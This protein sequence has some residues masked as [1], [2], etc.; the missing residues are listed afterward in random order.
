MGILRR[1][2]F[3]ALMIACAG[4]ARAEQTAP[5]EPAVW[6][7]TDA[8]S[9]IYLYGTIHIGISEDGWGGPIARAALAKSDE[10]WTE[11]EVKE[12]DEAELG[13]EVFEH[14][15]DRTQRL[16]RVLTPAR[17]NA[18]VAAL[19]GTGATGEMLDMMRPWLAAVMLDM[20][21]VLGKGGVGMDGVEEFVDDA[22]ELAGKKR[23]WF[24]TGEQQLGFFANLP[25]A[26]QMQYLNNSIDS[27]IA[28][29]AGGAS[30]VDD[31]AMM[32]AWETGDVDS[33]VRYVVEP[34]RALSPGVHKALLVDRNATWVETII[35]EM[36]GSGV[37]FM[38]VG[39]AHLAG[40]D[41][42][43]SMLAARGYKVTRL[44]APPS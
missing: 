7:L 40:R 44:T 21:G 25:A 41:S 9:T 23:R 17:W 27:Y 37:D 29:S 35:T 43:Q 5:R 34:M 38:A 20:S 12:Q 24:E 31:D 19:K 15:F 39:A 10:I 18:L 16:S 3:A 1:V 36:R 33:L 32:K 14:G 28:A 42:V 13:A 4:I 2:A 11:I 22:A 6:M 26:T 30:S 8:D